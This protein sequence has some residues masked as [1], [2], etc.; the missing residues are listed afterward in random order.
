MKRIRKYH[1]ISTDKL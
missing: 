1:I